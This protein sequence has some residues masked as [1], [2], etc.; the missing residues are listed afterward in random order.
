MTGLCFSYNEI[1]FHYECGPHAP[2]CSAVDG[3]FGYFHFLAI[4]NS[5][6]INVEFRDVFDR[7]ISVPSV[8]TQKWVGQIIW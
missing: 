6:T 2:I 1:E 3:H 4:M 8:H 7:L 5:A